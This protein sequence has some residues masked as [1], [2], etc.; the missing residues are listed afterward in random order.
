MSVC[1]GRAIPRGFFLGA[2]T[3]LAAVLAVAASRS[4]SYNG[5]SQPIRHLFTTPIWLGRAE[6]LDAATLSELELIIL[7]RYKELEPSLQ[8]QAADWTAAAERGHVPTRP[9]GSLVNDAFFQLQVSWE[10]DR[11]QGVRAGWIELFGSRAYQRAATAIRRAAAAYCHALGLTAAEAEAAKL[12]LWVNVLPPSSSHAPHIHAKALLSGTLW[13]S[14]G[15]DAGALA[16]RDPRRAHGEGLAAHPAVGRP[17]DRGAFDDEACD[18]RTTCHSRTAPYRPTR[19]FLGCRLAW[20]RPRA[21]LPPS[22]W[23]CSL[24]PACSRCSRPSST[25]T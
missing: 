17:A 25:T 13:I 16:F 1:D 10:R 22:R 19:S 21:P 24:R 20:T 23:S 11:L 8:Q 14:A 9:V 15:R 7:S 18:G 6:D 5:G 2:A 12:D 4:S 3:A